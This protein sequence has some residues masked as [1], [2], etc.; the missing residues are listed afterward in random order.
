[1]MDSESP[2][3]VRRADLANASMFV[4]QGTYP[5]YGGDPTALRTAELAK[6]GLTKSHPVLKQDV[7]EMLA[8]KFEDPLIGIIGLHQLLRDPHYDRGLASSVLQNLRRL[9]GSHPDVE[10][11]ARKVGLGD[12]R[13]V[14][15]APPMV[16]AG[17]DLLLDASAA[18]PGCVPPDSLPAQIAGRLWG[19]GAWLV[20]KVS[21]EPCAKGVESALTSEQGQALLDLADT[22]QPPDAA[23]GLFYGLPGEQPESEL[24]PEALAEMVRLLRIPASRVEEMLKQ[25]RG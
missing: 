22:L 5:P 21:P 23:E 14:F 7:F 24:T 18:Q 19:S 8:L 1:M 6:Q 15:T 13:Y 25:S 10:A 2:V 9:L 16:R 17:W 3:M 4:T 11:L 20:W 12:S